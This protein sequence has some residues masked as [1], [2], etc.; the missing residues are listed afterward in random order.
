MEKRGVIRGRQRKG[1]HR[2]KASSIQDAIN[3]G[4]RLSQ[5]KVSE[6]IG[7]KQ[8]GLSPY[9]SFD[10]VN[11]SKYINTYSI[12]YYCAIKIISPTIKSQ[13]IVSNE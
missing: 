2:G 9:L 13:K 3:L 6:E 10:F 4:G 11:I 5:Y 1:S 12:Q 7:I 8:D